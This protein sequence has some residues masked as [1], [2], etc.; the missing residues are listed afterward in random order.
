MLRREPARSWRPERP[1]LPE[2]RPVLPER[3]RPEL[4]RQPAWSPVQLPSS[5]LPLSWLPALR[6][7]Q[8]WLQAFLLL[9]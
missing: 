7:E 4:E 3:L 2:R 6:P 8:P 9:A 1:V 5:V